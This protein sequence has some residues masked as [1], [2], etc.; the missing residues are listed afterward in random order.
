MPWTSLMDPDNS[1]PYVTYYPA[2][3]LVNQTLYFSGTLFSD[4]QLTA[5]AASGNGTYDLEVTAIDA[6]GKQARRTADFEVR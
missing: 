5:I 2:D 6:A 3:Y 4:A 1:C